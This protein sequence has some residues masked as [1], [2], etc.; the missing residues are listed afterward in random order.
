M[1]RDGK[2]IEPFL[3]LKPFFALCFDQSLL[4]DWAERVQ[5][6]K[7]KSKLAIRKIRLMWL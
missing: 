4:A 6:P 1:W 7:E 2:T 3:F 5:S